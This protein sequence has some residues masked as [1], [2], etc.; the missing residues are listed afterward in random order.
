MAVELGGMTGMPANRGTRNRGFARQGA[1]QS[2]VPD[3]DH[4]A[5]SCGET[6]PTQR[7]A[8]PA[9]RP[10][11]HGP[12]VRHVDRRVVVVD[13]PSGLL[14]VPGRGIDKADCA[15]SRVRARWPGAL[16]VHRLD[17]DT[18]GLLLFAL[19]DDTQREMSRQFATR[20]IDKRY[21]ALVQGCPATDEGEVDLPLITDWPRRPRQMV[22][23]ETGKPS[24]TRWRVL[25]RDVDGRFSRV[26][27]TPLTGRSHQLRVHMAAIGHPLLGDPLYAPVPARTARE[28]LCLHA[29]RL[30]FTPAD[31]VGPLVVESPCPF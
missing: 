19:D 23:H 17:M 3:T 27:L 25:A 22:C 8:P 24:L 15:L 29:C 12:D 1:G 6:P 20:Q 30:E 18:S 13:K 11:S 14:S 4:A 28:R 21:E 7:A 10:P 31:E 2:G 16:V 5:L 9:Y 26:A